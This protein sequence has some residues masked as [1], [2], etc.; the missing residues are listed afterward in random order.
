MLCHR[1]VYAFLVSLPH[2][3][4]I[5]LEYYTPAE[6]DCRILIWLILKHYILE[7]QLNRYRNSRKTP[8][9][10]TAFLP[11]WTLG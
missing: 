8:P 7:V 9:N 5:F 1:I 10:A 3:S 11:Q 2:F 4:C 6:G